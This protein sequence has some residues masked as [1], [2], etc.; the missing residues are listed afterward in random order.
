MKG[1]P[2]PG[3]DV[4]IKDGG[5][6]R[7][8]FR[9]WKPGRVQL[10]DGKIMYLKGIRYPTQAE[11]KL[12]MLRVSASVIYERVSREL[13]LRPE[14]EAHLVDEMAALTNEVFDRLLE[15]HWFATVCEVCEETLAEDG[16]R[17]TLLDL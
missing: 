14:E 15:N 17:D 1:Y 5:E 13:F 10:D 8:V 12:A 4:V 7:T 3:E 16:M 11:A 6:L 2:K 9:Q